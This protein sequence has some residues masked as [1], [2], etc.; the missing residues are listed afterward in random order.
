VQN[1]LP[2]NLPKVLGD[3][4]RLEQV[5]GNLLSNACKYNRRGG[6][7]SLRCEDAAERVCVRVEDEGAG[8]SPALLAEL[9]QPFKRLQVSPDVPG[10]G[11]G[12]VV[13]KLLVGQM[14]GS[15]DVSSEPG[16]G[17]CFTVCLR[18]A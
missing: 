11:L 13:V 2:A 18:K 12:L 10:T 17:T 9:F 14:G 5:F 15:I 1:L 8:M 4:R 16:R 6:T 3:A 7:L